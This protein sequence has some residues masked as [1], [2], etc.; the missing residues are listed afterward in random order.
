[1]KDKTYEFLKDIAVKEKDEL[2]MLLE[3]DPDLLQYAASQENLDTLLE[4]VRAP[5][6]LKNSVL[7]KIANHEADAPRSD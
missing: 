6:G 3:N 5:R 1:M 4:N 2:K 7:R